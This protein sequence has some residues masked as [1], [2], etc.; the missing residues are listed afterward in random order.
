MA[1]PVAAEERA[2]HG[3]ALM[4]GLMI[5]GIVLGLFLVLARSMRDRAR[6]GYPPIGRP[7]GRRDR[8]AGLQ[9][10]DFDRIMDESRSRR[11]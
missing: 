3:P 8:V 6:A 2:D 4:E 5:L 11:R 10:A 7:T 9:D 1:T